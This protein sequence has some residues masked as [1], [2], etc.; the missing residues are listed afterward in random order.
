MLKTPEQMVV[1]LKEQM[2]GGQGTV[3]IKHIFQAGE[4]KGK[5]R[6]FAEITLPVG[7]SIGFHRH[8]QE[9][10][11]FYFLSGAGMI[12]DNGLMREVKAGEVL[13]TGNGAGH[14]VQNIGNDSLRMLAVILLYD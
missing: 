13:L 8:E 1:E 9:E 12:D 4:L 10:E 7:A 14:A 11:V 6:L 3:E 2:R 5:V